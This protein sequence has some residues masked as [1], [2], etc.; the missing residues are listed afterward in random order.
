MRHQVE[1]SLTREELKAFDLEHLD[2][3][4]FE[5]IS[6]LLKVKLN[7][8]ALDIQISQDESQAEA[9]NFDNEMIQKNE[10]DMK[11]YEENEKNLIK[12][13]KFKTKNIDSKDAENELDRFIKQ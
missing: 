6:H 2:Y 9:D 7:E 12:N 10:K 1:K 13:L 5:N 4:S 11:S 3:F 8:L